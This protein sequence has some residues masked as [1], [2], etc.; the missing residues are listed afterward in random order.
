VS[1]IDN[2]FSIVLSEIKNGSVYAVSNIQNNE[3]LIFSNYSNASCCGSSDIVNIVQLNNEGSYS[4]L[5]LLT[6]LWAMNNHSKGVIMSSHQVNE[7]THV[8]SYAVRDW[9]WF[10]KDQIL[11]ISLYSDRY[12]LPIFSVNNTIGQY[13]I[14]HISS[15]NVTGFLDQEYRQ[16]NNTTH[17]E[18]ISHNVAV[19]LES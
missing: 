2:N 12:A 18:V 19:F 9:N 5:P 8:M 16:Q 1:G 3:N 17:P 4:S 10:H 6:Y 14:D 15:V 13:I 7:S 11:G